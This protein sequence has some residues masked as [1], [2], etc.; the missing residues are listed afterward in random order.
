MGNEDGATWLTGMYGL[1]EM[2]KAASSR[3][4]MVEALAGLLK[5]S[6]TVVVKDATR[7]LQ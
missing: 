3:Q 5:R 1:Q 4:S 6:N 2:A 7:A